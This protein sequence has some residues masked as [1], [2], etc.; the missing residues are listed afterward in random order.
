MKKIMILFLSLFAILQPSFTQEKSTDAFSPKYLNWYN[1]DFKTANILG[2]SVDKAYN[3][4]LAGKEPKKVVT[5]AVIDGGV[6][7]NCDDLKGRIWVNEDEIPNDSIDNDNNGYVDDVHGWNF[8]GNASG[9][10]INFENY[11]STRIVKLGP[12]DPNYSLAK[13][14][15][16]E[17]LTKRTNDK[18]QIDKFEA[19]YNYAKKIV[20][21]ATGI[22]VTCSKD[23]EN[24]QTEDARLKAA[25][26]FLQG[27]YDNG[28]TDKWFADYKNRNSLFFTY[29]LNLDFN[30][31]AIIGDNPDDINDNHYG[32]PDVIGPR[33]DHGTCVA[34]I[35]AAI[36]NNG[37]GVDGIASSVKIMVLRVV[38]NGDERDKDVAL[39]IRYA[40][41][42]GA[43]II[44]MSF[45][46]KTT[47]HRE[48]VN[49]AIKYAGE[50]NVLIIHSAGNYGE[51]SDVDFNYP[52][53]V[54]LD[55]GVASNM[56]NVGATAMEKGDSMVCDFSNYGKKNVQIFAPGFNIISLDTCNTYSLHS[57]TSQ[58][59][60]VVTGIAATLL[61]Y[62]PDLKPKDLIE[63]MLKSATPFKREKVLV[64]DLKK[65]NK[66]RE[67]FGELST[68]G[69]IVNLY[70][71]LKVAE[72]YKK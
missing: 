16:D 20:K 18:A 41:D 47:T 70:E 58:A 8:I 15:Y 5:V 26:S 14:L 61:S 33:A 67:K 60:P 72:N 57:G 46:K 4:L 36:R 28:F 1:L 40:V 3:E 62:Y 7:I 52:T 30:P 44:N 9:Q 23:I 29:Y 35:I 17:E 65:Q 38:P 10:N 24:I 22:E 49:D 68:S 11:E 48:F 55:N 51:N 6:D 71:A 64:P 43:D 34:G 31:R 12:S 56:I 54:Y 32:N 25:V 42:N 53:R 66:G 63:I 59:S 19:K 27:R 2:T 13:S 39:A 69:G 50:K 45:G 37:T 21:D